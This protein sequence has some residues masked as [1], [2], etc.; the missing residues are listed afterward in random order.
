L[1]RRL[2]ATAATRSAIASSVSTIDVR[3]AT[4][5]DCGPEGLDRPITRQR[6]RYSYRLVYGQGSK[7]CVLDPATDRRP[8]AFRP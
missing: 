8:P 4:A 2:E 6:M 3:N 7:G 1:R 5:F